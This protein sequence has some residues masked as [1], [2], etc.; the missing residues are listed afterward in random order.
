[1]SRLRAWFVSKVEAL[2]LRLLEANNEGFGKPGRP[3]PPVTLEVRQGVDGAQVVVLWVTPEVAAREGLVLLRLPQRPERPMHLDVD[4]DIMGAAVVPLESF[5][6][7]YLD[8]AAV[9]STTHW[10]ASGA[11]RSAVLC[12][13][14]DSAA[15]LP[16]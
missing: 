3:Q 10:C 7:R 13:G 16:L 5:E 4:T 14:V 11:S 6:I 8:E 9:L 2:T 12:A 15:V 1:M